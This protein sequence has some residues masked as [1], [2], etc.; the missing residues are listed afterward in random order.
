MIDINQ[1]IGK[2]AEK[3]GVLYTPDDPVFSLIEILVMSMEETNNIT[4]IEVER[5]GK[6]SASLAQVVEV[7]CQTVNESISIIKAT[8]PRPFESVVDNLV[9]FLIVLFIGMF[10]GIVIGSGVFPK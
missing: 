9:A 1:I 8:K 10:F 2:L 6:S 7:S 3:T 5:L 4:R